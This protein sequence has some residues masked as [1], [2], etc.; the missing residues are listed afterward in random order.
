MPSRERGDDALRHV[1]A[2]LRS[3]RGGAI[4]VLRPAA[5]LDKNEITAHTFI[6]M[7]ASGHH[8]NCVQA[9]GDGHDS[10]A[11]ADF[12]DV[13]AIT[14]STDPEHS[15]TV[16]LGDQIQPGQFRGTLTSSGGSATM[17]VVANKAGGK[18]GLYAFGT[19]DVAYN[20]MLVE[21]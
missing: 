19:D 6:G 4:G 13:D 1:H 18:W 10:F 20:V 9:M 17:I 16:T 2:R 5:N 11:G 14:V 12:T 7:T 21:K 8:S 15:C 3:Q